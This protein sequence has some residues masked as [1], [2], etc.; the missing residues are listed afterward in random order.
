MLADIVILVHFWWILFLAFGIVFV[1]MKSKW[2]FLHAGGLLFALFLNLFEWYCPLTYIENY[3]H[4]QHSAGLLY[5]RPFL[6]HY[7]NRI[8]YPE[9]SEPTLRSAEMVFVLLNGVGYGWILSKRGLPVRR[10]ER[11]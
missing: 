10:G 6:V 3:L 9:V 1:L 7:L 8:V 11:R 4:S 2:A 5:D